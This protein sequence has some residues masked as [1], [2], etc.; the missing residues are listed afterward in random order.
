MWSYPDVGRHPATAPYRGLSEP[1]ARRAASQSTEPTS[2][3]LGAEK[4]SHERPLC[5]RRR[6]RFA[7]RRVAR[8]RTDFPGVVPRACRPF[9]TATHSVRSERGVRKRPS[10]ELTARTG[11]LR[12]K[13]AQ[14][15]PLNWDTGHCAGCNHEY[16]LDERPGGKGALI[17]PEGTVFYTLCEKCAPRWH[18]DRRFRRRLERDAYWTI[19]TAGPDDVAGTA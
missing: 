15:I 14:V 12:L 2:R 9:K 4:P 13:S 6:I 16:R 19:F 17:E 18:G 3:R 1:P 10:K 7:V 5:C 11:S 8:P